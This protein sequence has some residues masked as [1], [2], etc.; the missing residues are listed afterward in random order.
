[1]Q[2]TEVVFATNTCR[3]CERRD[4]HPRFSAR[5]MMFGFRDQFTYFECKGCGCVQIE[6]VPENLAKYYPNTYYSFQNSSPLKSYLKRQWAARAFHGKGLVG[7]LVARCLG[8]QQAVESVRRTNPPFDAAI[9][10]VG[11]GSGELLYLL[12]SLGFRDLT[13]VDPFLEK[14][15]VTPEGIKLWKKEL[16]ALDGQFDMLMM[17]HSFEHTLAPAEIVGHIHRLLKPRGVAI[18]RVPV[19]GSYAWKT[20]GVN[21]VGLDA[22]RHIFLPTAKSMQVL[23]DKAGFRFGEVAYESNEFQFWGSEQY[24]RDI[25]LNDA[26][27]YSR[28]IWKLA[29]QL[30]PIRG[31]RKQ[32]A[33]LNAQQQGDAA[34]FYFHKD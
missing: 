33:E 6:R 4:D 32:A 27:S 31:Y 5:E 1:M 3:I 13:G 25:P 29:L 7:G 12:S 14:D 20:Y 30:P 23:A 11:S 34:C 2:N 16:A 24:V 15:S 17:H 8:P 9:V 28:Q 10:D 21:W 26:R 22:P 19:A 18:L